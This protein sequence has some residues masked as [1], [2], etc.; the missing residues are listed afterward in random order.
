MS[1]ATR[2]SY[3][4]AGP[5]AHYLIDQTGNVVQAHYGEGKYEATEMLIQ[6]LLDDPPQEAVKS[7]TGGHTAGRTPSSTWAGPVWAGPVWSGLT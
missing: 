5:P 3:R 2:L 4:I 7:N 6:Q 1:R